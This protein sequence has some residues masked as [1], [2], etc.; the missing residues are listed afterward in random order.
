MTSKEI[1][2]DSNIKALF[3]AK[4]LSM[5]TKCPYSIDRILKN[6]KICYKIYQI[7]KEEEKQIKLD[8]EIER[9]QS[10]NVQPHYIN[11]SWGQNGSWLMMDEPRLFIDYRYN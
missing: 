5:E 1:I 6:K 3:I 7:S 9:R 11:M 10:R 4:K 2:V 8:A